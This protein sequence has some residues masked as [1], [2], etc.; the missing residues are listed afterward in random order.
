MKGIGYPGGFFFT[1]TKQA[2]ASITFD[3]ERIHGEIFLTKIVNK[4]CFTKCL[5]QNV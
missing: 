3:D 5:T 2:S 1:V 4:K